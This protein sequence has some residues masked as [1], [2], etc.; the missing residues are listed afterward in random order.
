MLGTHNRSGTRFRTWPTRVR[1]AAIV[2][3][4][5]FTITSTTGCRAGGMIL[6]RVIVTAAVTAM[7]LAAHDSHHHHP[8][9]GH[10]YVVIERQRVYHYQERWEYYDRRDGQWYYYDDVEVY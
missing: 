5:A 3:L 10:E 8:D 4:A 7:V 6:A 9:C 2:L 1:L